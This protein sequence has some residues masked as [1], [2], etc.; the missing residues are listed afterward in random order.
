M[1][2]SK[3]GL[4]AFVLES[5]ELIVSME[6]A[7]RQI[8]GDGKG[9]EAL[10]ALFRAAHTI[11][12]SASIFELEEIVQF[13]H[14]MES[15]LEKLRN[16]EASMSEDMTALLMDCL[17]CLG[18]LVDGIATGDKVTAEQDK[19]RQALADRL[20]QHLGEKATP[21]SK[22]G[23]GKKTTRKRGTSPKT[24]MQTW[25]LSLRFDKNVLRDGLNPL[26]LLH[27]M[28]RKGT[29]Q[30]V[31]VVT[32]SLPPA[33][34][35][36][37][38]TCYLGF[39]VRFETK[40][41]QEDIESVFAFVRDSGRIILVPPG[42]D[43][44][45]IAQVLAQFI[46]PH[47][48]AME[49]VRQG[50]FELREVQRYL[51]GLVGQSG[52]LPAR[53]TTDLPEGKHAPSKKYREG[54]AEAAVMKVEVARL[55]ELVDLVGE[56][57][58][59]GAAAKLAARI[60]GD[61]QIIELSERIETLVEGI[62]DVSMQMRMVRMNEIFEHIPRVVRDIAREIGKDID[63]TIR[64][65]DTELDKAM[66]EKI[67]Q[68][69]LHLVRNAADHGIETREERQRRSKPAT[70]HLEI[71]AFQDAGNI[72]IEVSDDGAGINRERVLEKAIATGLANVGQVYSDQEIL[73]FIFAQGISTADE[74]TSLSGR[75]VGMD[76]VQKAVKSLHGDI[77]VSS[78]PGKGTRFSMRFPL[79]LAIISGF[80]VIVGDMVLIIPL[81]SMEECINLAR[82]EVTDNMA[83][84]RGET[85]PFLSMRRLFGLPE[86]DMPRRNMVVVRYGNKHAGILVDGF[87]G[88]VHAVVKPMGRMFASMKA[89]SGAAILADGR[90]A[91]ILDV[92][93]IMKY[94]ERMSE[95]VIMKPTSE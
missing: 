14:K 37:P 45:E 30:A 31:M 4:D 62:R 23:T 68:P 9:D 52:P 59:A 42:E 82:Y 72:V 93:F 69:L 66:L 61:L 63:V 7:L 6:V 49:L 44:K 24:A 79:T 32:D 25:H 73:R 19:Y 58:I 29:M 13:A 85:L 78:V 2:T 34:R 18:S 12:G 75:G 3:V 39:E 21:Q 71:E 55:D 50:M 65:E 20:R 74:I 89:I 28:Q 8:Q 56:L 64:G 83:S 15:L 94:T 35:M 41:T 43:R 88:E 46:S 77:E 16:H 5:R 91:M 33:D 40:A 86:R 48:A 27:Y 36:D 60:R 92:Q 53:D 1:S 26:S 81:G 90:I 47:E 95:Q 84:F 76:V 87:V 17:D 51:P 80:Q 38:E 11:K 57:V 70:G 22:A 54:K 10:H 67:S